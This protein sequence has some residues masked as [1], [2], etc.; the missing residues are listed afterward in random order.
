MKAA[1]LLIVVIAGVATLTGCAPRPASPPPLSSPPVTA[2]S[3]TPE[4][5]LV[6]KRVVI[7]ATD[8][9]LFGDD[10]ALA[11][12]FSY[13]DATAS[14]VAALTE[15]FGADPVITTTPGSCCHE[16]PATHYTWGGFLLY[17]SEMLVVQPHSPEFTIRVTSAMVAGVTIETVDG[18]TVGYSSAA[19]EASQPGTAIRGTSSSG[20]YELFEVAGVNFG[21]EPESGTGDL[22][23][24][25]TLTSDHPDGTIATIYA[26]SSNQGD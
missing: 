3:T 16:F 9:Q 14:A 25:V 18:I 12:T 26:P 21:S 4:P 24:S 13:F 15:Q 7:T 17:D 1:A 2:P 10:G 11:T 20:D 22:I 5:E 8:V 23:I 19:V 6:P